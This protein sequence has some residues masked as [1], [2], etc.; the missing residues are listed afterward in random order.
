MTYGR[1]IWA[2][3]YHRPNGSGDSDRWEI[4][5]QIKQCSIFKNSSILSIYLVILRIIE[6]GEEKR[7]GGK[8]INKRILT[9]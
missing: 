4:H 3:N 1:L 2:P 5:F 8:E 6:K 7:G 9:S